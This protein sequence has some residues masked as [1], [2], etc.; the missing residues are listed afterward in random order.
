MPRA[1][2]FY[3]P[4]AVWHITHRCHDRQFLLRFECDRLR[5]KY[6]LFQA[7]KRYG[8]V[9]LNYIVTSNHVHLL[10]QDAA[11]GSIARA[12]QLVAGRTAQE[13]NQRKKR[14]GSF[15][16][17]RYFATVVATDRHLL[18][19]LVYIDLNMV[20]AGV[21]NH[22]AQWRVCGFNE[23]QNPPQRYRIID[24]PK[25]C[26]LTGIAD[27]PSLQA[28]H[29]RWVEDSLVTGKFEREPRWTESIAVGPRSYVEQVRK[30]LGV[31]ALY[32]KTEAEDENSHVIRDGASA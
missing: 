21:V 24:R 8:L 13:Y 7:C 29:G 22:P 26:F 15:W 18:R 32:R 4:N 30:E 12:M 17:D 16:E 6:W 10:V 31:K 11:P 5:W 9:V 3:I 2:R 25:L 19:C 14:K 1:N 23:I 27:M 28:A 20:R